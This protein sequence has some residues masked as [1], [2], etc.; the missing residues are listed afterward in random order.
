MLQLGALYRFKGSKSMTSLDRPRLDNI[1]N[2]LPPLP[3]ASTNPCHRII[4]NSNN[5]ARLMNIIMMMN[6][7]IACSSAS[8]FFNDVE[9][10]G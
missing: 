5:S 7:G 10:G 9:G 4:I 3:P 6:I 1:S 2:N 8:F